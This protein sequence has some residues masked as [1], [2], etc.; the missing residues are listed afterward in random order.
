M[1][2]KSQYSASDL[3]R[4]LVNGL[5]SP[6]REMRLLLM[7]QGYIDDSGSDGSQSSYVLAGYILP[8][9]KWADFSDDW[10]AELRREPQ[11]EYFKMSEALYG[12][13]EFLGTQEEFRKC[14][15]RD[16]LRVITKHNPD[17]ICSYLKWDEWRDFEQCLPPIIRKPYV[18]LFFNVLD[19]VVF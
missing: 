18:A 7:L 8:A 3:I 10:S 17:G 19:S 16:L 2:A 6:I 11:I 1:C 5:P 15:A 9:E 12:N 14:K 13:G 4:F